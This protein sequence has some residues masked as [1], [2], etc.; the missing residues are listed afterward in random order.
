MLCFLAAILGVV[1]M[2]DVCSSNYGWY[3]PERYVCKTAGSIWP[4][5][6]DGLINDKNNGCG[7]WSRHSDNLMGTNYC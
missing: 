6:R 1:D 5:T 4:E 2:Q 3:N 7:F